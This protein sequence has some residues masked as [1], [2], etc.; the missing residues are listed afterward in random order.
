VFS[1]VSLLDSERAGSS[2]LKVCMADFLLRPPSG[3]NDMNAQCQRPMR[4]K[5]PV[6]AVF[7]VVAGLV[8]V[9]ALHA[10]DQTP[11]PV[12]R[13]IPSMVGQLMDHDFVNF[14]VFGNAIYDSRIPILSSTGQSIGS[15]SWGYQAGG[16]VTL[17]H[18]FYDGD[19][20]LSYRGDYRGYN[21][22][23]YGSG[24]DQNLSLL[25]NKRLSRHWTVS[26]PV[27]AG[28]LLYGAGGYVVSPG[29]GGAISPNPLSPE[30]RFV[31]AGVNLTYQQSRR[32]SYVFS[33]SFFV[34]NYNYVG[35][36]GST[37]VSGS[38]S[39]LYRLTGKTTAGVTYSH[40]YYHYSRQAGTTSVDG[41]SLSLTHDFPD[42]WQ[43]SVSAG[44]NRADTQGILTQ[45]V[46]ILLGQQVIQGYFTGPYQ[47]TSYVP[48]FQGTLTRFF[49]H[50]SASITGGQGVMPGNGTYL[51]SRD[52][53]VTALYNITTRRS[54]IGAAY[55]FF[56]LT[57]I[58]NLV[59]S[60]YTTSSLSFSYGY[61]LRR[62]LSANAS[63][64]Y[65]HYGSLFALNSIN[66]NIFTI[67][68]SLSTKSLP[69]GLF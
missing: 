23:S 21:S 64:S 15:G 9:T 7:S 41:L 47:R 49:R 40:S 1:S 42:H 57:S 48:S 10:Q 12:D 19:I 37:G 45:D 54:N 20:S 13:S 34:N 31:Q 35:A 18:R 44:V 27:S 17:A 51:T 25:Y 8:A 16:G 63:Y 32:L 11:A 55:S 53:F 58:S 2:D 50:S 14:Y 61:T 67:G 26:L 6:R 56:H 60:A 69:L 39:L 24:T 46:S 59:T 62:H 29:A 65:L 22:S 30:T 36:I 3:L 38:G 43:G 33:G 5:F 52:Q 4:A 68:L 66:D 28:I